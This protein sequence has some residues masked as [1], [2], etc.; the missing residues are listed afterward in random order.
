MASYPTRRRRHGDGLRVGRALATPCRAS[1]L[2]ANACN[3]ARRRKVPIRYASDIRPAM[4]PVKVG[5]PPEAID[6]VDAMR[7]RISR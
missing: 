5:V 1:T 3:G 4:L 6:N 2:S 7:D